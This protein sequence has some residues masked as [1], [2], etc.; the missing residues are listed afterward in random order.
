MKKTILITGAAGGIGMA[1]SKHFAS[2]GWKV[3]MLDINPKLSEM[4]TSIDGELATEICD[5]KNV[6]QVKESITKIENSL[7]PIDALINNAG[8][9]SNIRPIAKMSDERWHDELSINLSSTFYFIR[10]LAPKM[11]ERGWGRII[12]ISSGAARSG[13]PNQIGYAATKSALW[14][15]TSTTA[16]EFGKKGVTCNSILPGVIATPKVL[17]M[18]SFIIDVAK[19]S[20]SVKRLGE[21]DEIA[22]LVAYLCSDKAGFI[23]GAEIDIDGGFRLNNNSM[24]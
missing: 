2:N 24:G 21:V 17:S 6:E 18:P 23:T 10:D 12:N 19:M 4:A 11:A 8:W 13:L 7:G 3:G 22:N 5:V 9:V 20:S 14:G 15:I 16:A 1:I